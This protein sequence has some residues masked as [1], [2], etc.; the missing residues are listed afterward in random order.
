MQSALDSITNGTHLSDITFDVGNC[1][2]TGG[3]A[4]FKVKC[5]L[6][7]AKTREQ[8][9]LEY[10]ADMHDIDTT[11]IAQLQ[12]ED[13]KIIGYKSRA[14]KKPWILQRLRDGAEFV[15]GDNLVKQFFKKREE[16]EDA[17]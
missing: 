4:T 16:L 15:A 10:Y 14:R 2:Y 6:K 3:E 12:G 13:M 8:I 11:A 7:G 5:L 1:S 17:N 9:D